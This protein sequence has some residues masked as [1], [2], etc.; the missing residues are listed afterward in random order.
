MKAREHSKSVVLCDSVG[1][2]YYYI[3]FH[4]F[5][6][7]PQIQDVAIALSLTPFLCPYIHCYLT[8]LAFHIGTWILSGGLSRACGTRITIDD[9]EQGLKDLKDFGASLTLGYFFS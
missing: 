1:R 2:V 6:S 3:F 4:R 5:F 8:S 7:R 9:K